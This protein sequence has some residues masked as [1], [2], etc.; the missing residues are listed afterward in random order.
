VN[1][2]HAFHAGNFA[3]VLKHL[4]LV[5]CLDHLRQKETAFR[6]MDVFAGIGLYDLSSAE[7]I[8]NPEWQH[9]IARL[10]AASDLP[11]PLVRYLEAC[12]A[13][14]D[15]PS[16]YPGS[17]SFIA[18]A[19]RTQDKAMLCELHPVDF[20]TLSARFSSSKQIKIEARDGWGAVR[21]YLP[22]IERR[23]LVLIDPPFEQEGEFDRL[24]QALEEGLQR[25]ATGTFI[26][27]HADKDRMITKAYRNRLA[28][29]G[30]RILTVDLHVGQQNY[31]SGLRACG[32]SIANP[33]FGLEDALRQCGPYLARI[34]AQGDGEKYEVQRISGHW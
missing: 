11:P 26:L 1:Y 27:W 3:D 10:R 15:G 33:P 2:R 17:P 4:C 20:Q 24:G 14:G 9:G 34:L 30:A 16:T 28:G 32:L 29:T 21:A 5:L 31:G 22:P 12:D 7:A 8:R 18:E 19:L 13:A 6:V 23:G 25:W